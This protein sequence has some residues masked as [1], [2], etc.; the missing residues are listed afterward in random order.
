MPKS[1]LDLLLVERGLASTRE[2]ARALILAG[3]VRVDGRVVDKAGAAI[4]PD[5]IV[6]LRAPDHPWVGR[7]GLKLA[8]ALDQFGLDVR[9]ATATGACA[10]TRESSPSKASTRATSRP[11]CCR[12]TP[13]SSSS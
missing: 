2:R 12:R 6:T 11:I 13:G 10:P 7:G 9:G 4:A 5:A 3:D 8:H 1:R